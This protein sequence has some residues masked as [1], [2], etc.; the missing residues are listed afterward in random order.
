MELFELTDP[1]FSS[2]VSD[3]YYGLREST[4]WG[5][6]LVK[7]VRLDNSPQ[8]VNDLWLPPVVRRLRA[9]VEQLDKHNIIIVCGLLPVPFEKDL[10]RFLLSDPLIGHFPRFLS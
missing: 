1:D 8:G 7:I 2:R 5:V 3:Q 9:D 4:F 6:F 10:G